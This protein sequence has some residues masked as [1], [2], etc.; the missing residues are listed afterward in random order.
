MTLSVAIIDFFSLGEREGID[1]Q[2]AFAKLAQLY[3][4]VDFRNQANTVS[5]NLPCHRGCDMCCHESVF[6]TPL[7]FFYVW[8]WAQ[9]NLDSATRE[10]MVRQGL[11]LYRKH[12]VTIE[13]LNEAPPDGATDHFA[14][15]RDL[16]FRC[17]LLSAGGGCSVYPAREMAAR[18]FGCS[19]NDQGGIYGC[20]LVS[21]HL[22]D[23][24]V[25]LLPARPTLRRLKDLPL[26]SSRQVYP[27][28]FQLLFG[29]GETAE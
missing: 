5:L 10:G 18:I 22:K 17:P 11:S 28:Y 2:G 23:Q 12:Q 15:V 25:T 7:E 21:A 20:H 27:Y 8:H 3:E 29:G 9:N 1:L 16:K 4:E 24:E 14:L 26:T 19:F 6:L 13:A